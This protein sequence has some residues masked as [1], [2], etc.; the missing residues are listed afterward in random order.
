MLVVRVQRRFAHARVG[1][2]RRAVDA[3]AVRRRQDVGR[4]VHL[5][6]LLLLMLLLMLLT[7]DQEFV[8][9]LRRQNV[10]RFL[11][12]RQFVDETRQTT[13][14]CNGQ[15]KSMKFIKL[16]NFQISQN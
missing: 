11:K 12:G 7:A 9:R 2:R 13:W 4:R 10:S 14:W 3:V 15:M 16:I 5:L 8:A 1:R 6:L